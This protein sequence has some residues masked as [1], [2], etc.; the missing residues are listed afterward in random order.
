[1]DSPGQARLVLGRPPIHAAGCGHYGAADGRVKP[2]GHECGISSGEDLDVGWRPELGP[3]LVRPE[4][5]FSRRRHPPLDPDNLM[6]YDVEVS[7]FPSSHSGHSAA[8]LRRTTIRGPR[9][10]S[11]GQLDL[12]VLKWENPRGRSSGSGSGWGLRTTMP[13]L[14]SLEIPRSTIGAMEYGRRLAHDEVDFISAVRHP[15][16]PWEL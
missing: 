13:R 11:S 8:R 9:R 6:R 5:R 12:P 16:P 14:P 7:G 10:S 4:V 1:M 3:L 15:G 2:R